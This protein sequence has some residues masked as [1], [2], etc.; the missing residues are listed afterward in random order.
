M[1]ICKKTSPLFILIFC[2]LDDIRN[3]FRFPFSLLYLV[4][5]QALIFATDSIEQQTDN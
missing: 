3:L 1:V 5:E 4:I 2:L